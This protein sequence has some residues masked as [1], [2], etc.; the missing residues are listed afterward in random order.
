MSVV[1]GIDGSRG[2]RAAIRLAAKEARYRKAPLVA[3]M[4]Y[5]GDRAPGAPAGRPIAGLH[6]AQDEQTI[7]ESSLRDTVRD[8]LGDEADDVQ[9][10]VVLGL[11][12]RR[13][14]DAAREIRAQLIVLATRG[15]MSLFLGT[16]NQYVLRNAPCPVLI[17]PD[18]SKRL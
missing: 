4:A 15:S 2:S 6:T 11:A 9:L 10:R 5:A 16:V 18:A 12:G 7:A 13:L 1:V 8:A 3:V 17:V 14:V